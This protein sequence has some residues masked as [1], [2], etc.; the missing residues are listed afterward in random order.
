[1]ERTKAKLTLTNG[2]DKSQTYPIQWK[3][4]K[5]NLHQPMERTKAKLTPSN[6]EDKSQTSFFFEGVGQQPVEVVALTK[7]PI[8][9]G[10]QHFCFVADTQTKIS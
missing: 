4:Q 5:P 7:H 3:G 2:E 8:A 6:G 10:I 9:D 1:M